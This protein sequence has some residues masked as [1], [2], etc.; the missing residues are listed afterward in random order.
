MVEVPEESSNNSC[1]KLHNVSL[2]GLA[3]LSRRAL[4][5]GQYVNIYFPIIDQTHCFNGEVVWVREFSKGFDTGVQ[6][7]ST[8]ELYSLRMIQQVCHIEHYRKEVEQQEDRKL[9]SEEAASEWI[10]RY[11]GVFPGLIK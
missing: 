4:K 9:S 11:A 3:F 6:F 2:G 7:E 1:D 8:D 10:K 5:L